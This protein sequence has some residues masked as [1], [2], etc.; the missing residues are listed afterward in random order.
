M[1]ELYDRYQAWL[2][3]RTDPPAEVIKGLHG[4]DTDRVRLDAEG[5]A[6]NNWPVAFPPDIAVQKGDRL[7]FGGYDEDRAIYDGPV[8]TPQAGGEARTI[9]LGLDI[10]AAPETAVYAPLDGRIHSFQDNANPKD[11]GP[12]LIL[13]HAVGELVFYTLYG[14][15][16]RDSLDGLHTGKTFKAGDRIAALGG[17]QVNGGW[18]PHLHFQVILDMME[19]KGDYPG[20]F[21]LSERADWKRICPDPGPLLGLTS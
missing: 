17:V 1:S 7:A 19:R 21:K 13:E 9:H 12:T 18:T 14:H 20:V 15:L 2:A 3:T 8:F 4:P 6:A 11:Y 16:S 10:F 5:L